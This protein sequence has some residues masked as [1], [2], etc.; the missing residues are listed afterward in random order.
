MTLLAGHIS[1]E[2]A[3]SSDPTLGVEF[4][5]EHNQA[6]VYIDEGAGMTEVALT[7]QQIR[8]FSCMVA[9]VISEMEWHNARWISAHGLYSTSIWHLQE[10]GHHDKY[11]KAVCGQKPPERY[12]SEC[13]W[14]LAPVI[15]EPWRD[16][17]MCKRCL[18][19]YDKRMT[20]DAR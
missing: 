14:D 6:V 13:R 12:P 3:E 5:P 17:S 1:V 15:R 4:E 20:Q 10:K 16:S 19:I 9:S 2:Q 8:Q 7:Y 18:A 11:S